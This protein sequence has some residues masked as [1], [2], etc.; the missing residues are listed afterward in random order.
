MRSQSC[1]MTHQRNLGMDVNGEGWW[2]MNVEK[3]VV[4]EIGVMYHYQLEVHQSFE[5]GFCDM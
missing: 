3:M 5:D 1:D 2:D 4:L